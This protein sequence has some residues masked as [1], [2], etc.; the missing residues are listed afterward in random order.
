MA[1]TSTT[2]QKVSAEAL[3]TFVLVFFGC[4][5]V[6]FAN[7]AGGGADYVAVGFTFGLAVLLMAYAVGRISGGHFNPAV[8]VGAAMG[9]RI[10]WRQVPVYVGAQLAGAIVAG[11]SLFVLLHGF[12]NFD[13]E[14]NMGQNFFGDEG[15]GYA[16]WAAFLLELILTMLFIMVIL[17]VTDA[18][19]EHPA[20]APLAIGLTLTA[21]HFV[22]IPA[23]GTS[24]NPARSIGPALFAGGDAIVQLWLF[25]LAPAIGGALGG[26]V[27][28]LV[29]GHGTDP[30][31]GSGLTFSRPS[32]AAVPGYG[33][34][35]QF[36]QEWNQQQSAQEQAAW[37]QEPIIQDGWQWDHAAQEWKPLEQ[38]Q[39]P[40]TPAQSQVEQSH[41][42]Q[43]EVEQPPAAQPPVDP[44]TQTTQMRP[45]E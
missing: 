9:G 35:D 14:G 29:F 33:A 10:A 18:R 19:F 25:I 39:P 26:L 2:V 6:V 41:V 44:G 23:T 11:L 42:V 16:W 28:P 32:P 15:S 4:G 12:E 34:P 5:S 21:I 13:S 17:A 36:Q 37:E 7:N 1:D 3:G 40:A 27:Y 31:P 45:P 38:W 43:P 8:S 20:L 30:V 22:A 24:V